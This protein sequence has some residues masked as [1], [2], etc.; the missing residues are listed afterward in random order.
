[1]PGPVCP[2]GSLQVLLRG[3]GKFDHDLTSRPNPGNDVVFCFF[4]IGKSSTFMAQHFSLMKYCNAP[5][6]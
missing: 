2:E 5:R 6:S 4:L 3:L 1:M